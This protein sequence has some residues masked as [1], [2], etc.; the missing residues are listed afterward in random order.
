L[1]LY[2]YRYLQGKAENKNADIPAGVY[3]WIPVAK[4][5]ASALGRLAGGSLLEISGLARLYGLT[6]HVSSF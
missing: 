2:Q 5:L 4:R 3:S 1:G 6:S